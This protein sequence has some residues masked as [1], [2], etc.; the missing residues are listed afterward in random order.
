MKVTKNK[1]TT[2]QR[3]TDFVGA[4]LNPHVVWYLWLNYNQMKDYIVA[5]ASKE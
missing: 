3:K 2:S 4:N 5:I 1:G